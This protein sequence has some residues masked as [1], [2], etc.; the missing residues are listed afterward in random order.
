M[1]AIFYQI[2]ANNLHSNNLK[3]LQTFELQNYRKCSV[4][5]MLK[6][7]EQEFL[8]WL[9][10]VVPERS[11][12]EIKNSYKVV[13]AMLLQ[14]KLLPTFLCGVTQAEKIENVLKQ[15]STVFANKQLRSNAIKLLNGYIKFLM[16]KE[17]TD[18]DYKVEANSVV[19]KQE[20]WIR[21]D[22]TNAKEF[23]RTT[24]V[25][26][27]LNGETITGKNWA[28][29]LVAIVENEIAKQNPSID[30]LYNK[31]LLRNRTGKPFFLK[32]KLEG[33][34]CSELSNGCWVN[35][36][37]SIP[38]L[39]DSIGE[40]CLH[41]GYK[42]EE[43]IIYGVAKDK[44]V[45]K[46]TP[47]TEEK[48]G[49][50]V[51][52]GEENSVPKK[53]GDNT[54]LQKNVEKTILD[55]DLEGITLAQ[56]AEKFPAVTMTTLK[57]IRDRSESTIVFYSFMLHKDALVDLDDAAEEFHGIIEYL[58]T[59]NDGYVSSAQLFEFACVKMQMFLNDNN[60][61][62][63]QKV[64]C[65]VKYLFDKIG[66]H[67]YHYNFT[68]GRHITRCG[69]ETIRSNMDV[70]EKFARNQ[71]GIF[72]WNDL[73]LYLEK[74]GIKPNNLRVQMEIGN[75]PIFFYYTSE[76]LI[77]AESMQIDNEWIEKAKRALKILFSDVGDHIVIRDIDSYWY[78]QLPELPKRL[79]WT[80]LLL[81]YVIRFYGA[82]LGART[83]RTELSKQYD[84]IHTFLVSEDCELQTFGDAIIAYMIDNHIEER[85]LQAEQ[86]RQIL[87][88][89]KLIGEYELIGNLPRSI[90][91]DPRF[92]WDAM[93]E[94]VNIRI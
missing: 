53:Q 27:N 1:Y 57:N 65:I 55:A 15:I 56:L 5:E 59:K 23:E 19:E 8:L 21:F 75:K 16:E 45:K 52:K 78:E 90:G 84:S 7:K 87:V 17:T 93:G 32:E 35:V 68:S 92:A 61:N 58:L 60:I 81:Q 40:L 22:F 82:K 74:V 64:F 62:D 76:M 51:V 94:N 54:E 86:L 30:D 39:M 72:Q 12:K 28:R 18:N 63:E 83:I 79:G 2:S 44:H 34:N 71:G 36:N 67:G 69:S 88:D 91:N 38:R 37:Y 70:F 66:W 48:A 46:E 80:P 42:K 14:K 43:V 89:G 29:I 33:L 6:S 85:C 50:I 47:E 13:N 25:S 41:C 31:P 49:S 11:L 73:L 20:N 26:C 24:P 4:D 10:N 9:Q 77:T 3:F